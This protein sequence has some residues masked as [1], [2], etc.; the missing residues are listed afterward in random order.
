MLT[1]IT[2]FALAASPV[3]RSTPVGPELDPLDGSTVLASDRDWLPQTRQLANLADFWFIEV[4]NMQN[5]GGGIATFD[6][7]YTASHGRSRTLTGHYWNGAN[8]TDP[9]RPGEPL[10]QLPYFAWD[11]IRYESLS[12]T[13]P[14]FHLRFEPEQNRTVWARGSLGANVGG[15]LF[16]PAGFMDREPS[17]DFGASPTVRELDQAQEYEA[18]A[19]V[20]GELG[21]LRLIAERI[22]H[23]RQFPTFVD[24]QS[25]ELLDDTSNRETVMGVGALA[26]LVGEE[27]FNRN[28]EIEA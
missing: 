5:S 9:S 16:I 4:V 28:R 17:F 23:R 1:L 21:A 10:V 25:G 24:P 20:S 22:D 26:R 19:S 18:Q 14:G 27:K 13:E 12:S 7:Q 15:P 11:S 3:E 8:V 6:P 2:Y